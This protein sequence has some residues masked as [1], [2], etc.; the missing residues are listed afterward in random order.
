MTTEFKTYKSQ[1]V[2]EM[3]GVTQS[4][5]RKWV[6]AGELTARFA[7]ERKRRLVIT[8]SDLKKFL[9][10]NPKYKAVWDNP[11]M[12]QAPYDMKVYIKEKLAILRELCIVLTTN[13]L[14]YLWSLKTEFAVDAFIHDVITGKARV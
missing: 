7:D 12:R 13:Q 1:E 11:M 5:V 14:I 3:L 9:D 10:K 8:E 4:T 6:T 2:A